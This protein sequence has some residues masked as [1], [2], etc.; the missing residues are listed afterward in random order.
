MGKVP[1]MSRSRLDEL[2]SF[3]RK[4]PQLLQHNS[5]QTGT[6]LSESVGLSSATCLRRVQRLRKIGAIEREVAVVSPAFQSNTTSIIVFLTANRLDPKRKQILTHKLLAFDEVER[7][8]SV[9][10]ED[11]IVLFVKFPSMEQFTDFADAH[12]YQQTI[13]GYESIVVLREFLRE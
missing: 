4:I 3:D 12:F 9:T 11:D 13:E 6:D 2:D 10:G 5:R 8:F 1:G 7:I